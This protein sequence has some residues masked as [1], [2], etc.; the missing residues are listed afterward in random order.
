MGNDWKN[1]SD[2]EKE[3]YFGKKKSSKKSK[4]ADF[5]L[6]E[7]QY[8]LTGSD[9][10]DVEQLQAEKEKFEKL[11]YQYE[12]IIRQHG[13]AD[14]LGKEFS[15]EEFICVKGIASI[16]KLVVN[17]IVTKD[18]VNMFDVLYRNLNVIRGIKPVATKKEKPK[19]REELVS[20]IKGGK[21]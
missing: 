9:D 14:L 17:E 2:E 13:L 12:S 15:D 7:G 11:A 6:G 18:D 5:D 21:A 3:S 4:N 8:D 1:M 19:T 10:I 16:K 20:I